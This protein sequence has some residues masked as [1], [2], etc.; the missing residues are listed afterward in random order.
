MASIIGRY[1]VENAQYNQ[2]DDGNT[3][4]AL[5]NIAEELSHIGHN[6]LG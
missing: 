2:A 3:Q 4:L 1:H 6:S 5:H